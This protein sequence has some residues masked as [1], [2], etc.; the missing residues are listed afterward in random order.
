[1]NPAS[2]PYKLGDLE[3]VVQSMPVSSFVEYEG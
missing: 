3:H 1:M 2:P